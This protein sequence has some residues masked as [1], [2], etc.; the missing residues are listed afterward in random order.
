MNVLIF[1]AIA[2]A[3]ICAGFT[4]L[5]TS[6][7]SNHPG[8]HFPDANTP[9]TMYPVQIYPG[10]NLITFSDPDGIAEI[11]PKFDED[12][13][14]LVDVEPIEISGDC[15][16]SVSVLLHVNSASRLLRCWFVVTDCKKRRKLLVPDNAYWQ[17]QDFR[18]PD[19]RV[20]ETACT[21]FRILVGHVFEID[22][23]TIDS[24]TCDLSGVSVDMGSP[25]PLHLDPE[26]EFF[27]DVCFSG[28]KPGRYKFGVTTWVQRA[29]PNGRYKNFPVADSGIAVVIQASDSLHPSTGE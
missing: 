8:R 13:D 17:L 21:K 19:S 23:E 1:S 27:Y 20:G 3:A 18:L 29:Q 2:V 16:D 10:A 12:T 14:S 6:V 5:R 4:P 11:L 9:A 7:L 15:P 28:K 24:V 26:S 25:F 22:G